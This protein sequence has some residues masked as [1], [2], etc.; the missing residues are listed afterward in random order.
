MTVIEQLAGWVSDF[1]PDRI[2]DTARLH[3]RLLLLD[4]IGCALAAT[5]EESC[6]G[7]IRAAQAL[8]GSGQCT[9]VGTPVRTSAPS[10]V[11]ANGSLIRCLDMNDT[12]WGKHGMAGHPSDNIAVALSMGEQCGSSGRELLTAI[13][14]GY[15]IDGRLADMGHTDHWDY[16]TR[17]R[18]VAPAIAGRLMGLDIERLTDALAL[19]A[20]LG[21]SLAIARSGQMSAAKWL[22]N[23]MVG[24]SGVAA[25]QLAAEGLQ[26]PRTVIEGPH[27]W[28]DAVLPEHDLSQLAAPVDGPYCIESA[29]IKAY[30]S[31]A[32]SQTSVAAA[33]QAYPWLA[34]RAGE[35][36]SVDVRMA[37]APIV[38]R[39]IADVERRYPRSHETADHSFYFLVA[40]A[41]LDGELTPRQFE[42]ERW[43]DPAV[44]A[45]MDRTT[46]RADR[47]LNRYLPQSFPAGLKITLRSGEQHEVEVPYA[48][49]HHYAG[50]TED[51]V[52]EKFRT[53]A[54]G[55]LSLDAVAQATE[56]AFSLERQASLEP[57]MA[58]LRV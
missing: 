57:L 54:S 25:A 3:A 2:S 18:F 13:V 36:E 14:L 11:L 58:L 41:L 31:L 53:Y 38:V 49:G 22:A 8:G 40:V 44:Q 21:P 33:L 12:Y 37:D 26:G 4:S 47:E 29:S 23:A 39:Q 1:E 43:L 9:I 7:V 28:A 24:S 15:E 34:G 27:G 16:P 19:G 17:S 10:A 52:A 42:H 45:L 5:H 20:F 35:I 6:Q 55:R 48:P 50:M 32:T 51:V 30:P 46:F 56:F